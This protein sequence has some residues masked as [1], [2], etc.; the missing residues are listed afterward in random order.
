[1]Y[2][3]Q[4][5]MAQARNEDKELRIRAQEAQA[6]TELAT[7]ALTAVSAAAAGVCAGV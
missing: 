7:A 3:V 1:M 2:E 6:A 4:Q 5:G